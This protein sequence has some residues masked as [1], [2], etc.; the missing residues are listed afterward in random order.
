MNESTEQPQLSRKTLSR[1]KVRREFLRAAKGRKWGTT[2]AVLQANATMSRQT[3]A[4]RIGFTAT[5]R[6]GN[7]VV[8]NRAKR[9]LRAAAA[10]V[11]PE[12][13]RPGFDYVLI[14]RP[15]ALTQPYKLLLD[16]IREALKR[17]HQDRRSKG[18]GRASQNARRRGKTAQT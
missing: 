2:S 9:R 8:R 4:M 1:L 15:G 13:G 6:L 5:K 12:L 16:D 18:R 11:F 3:D 10:D 14:A 17:V 7:A